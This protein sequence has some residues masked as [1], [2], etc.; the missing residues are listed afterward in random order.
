MGNVYVRLS[1]PDIEDLVKASIRLSVP[2]DRRI[3]F[4]PLR[5]SLTLTHSLFA[6]KRR[7]C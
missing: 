4:V 6:P 3:A 2:V 7:A 5:C 1:S